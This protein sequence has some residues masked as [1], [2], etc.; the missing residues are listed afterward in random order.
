MRSLLPKRCKHYKLY[1]KPKDKLAAKTQF[2]SKK[3]PESLD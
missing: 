1:G 3:N 2:L